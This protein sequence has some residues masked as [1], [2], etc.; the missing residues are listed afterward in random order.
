MGLMMHD[1]RMHRNSEDNVIAMMIRACDDRL[2]IG[3]QPMFVAIDKLAHCVVLLL[4]AALPRAVVW[5]LCS[6][7]CSHQKH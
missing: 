2:P 7:S 5:D 3:M 1:Y 4:Q 6:S